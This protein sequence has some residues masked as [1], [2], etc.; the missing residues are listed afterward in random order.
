MDLGFQDGQE[1][2]SAV[3]DIVVVQQGHPLLEILDLDGGSDEIHKEGKTVYRRKGGGSLFRHEGRRLDDFRGEILQG[4]R[5]D[6]DSLRALLV[7]LAVVQVADTGLYVWLIGRNPLD[8]NTMERLQNS[9]KRAVRHLQGLD[10]L[11]NRSETEKVVLGR[12]L[13]RNVILRHGA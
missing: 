6:V 12:I 2:H 8:F 10:D 1:R 13:D 5:K 3:E 7:G 4:T 11:A 9:R